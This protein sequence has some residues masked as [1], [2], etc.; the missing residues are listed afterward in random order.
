MHILT[1]NKCKITLEV[2]APL[3]LL[4]ILGAREEDLVGVCC[5]AIGAGFALAGSSAL[6][7]AIR[8]FMML[9][10]SSILATLLISYSL[11]KFTSSSESDSNSP[12]SKIFSFLLRERVA[13]WSYA[14]LSSSS[15][16]PSSSSSFSSFESY[17]SASAS[18]TS[19]CSG[20]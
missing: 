11:A 17:V 14:S 12:S 18:S 5:V 16:F 10:A 7:L 15:L 6:M 3:C 2:C 4:D 1:R 8:F 13:L 9:L 20:Q 19:F